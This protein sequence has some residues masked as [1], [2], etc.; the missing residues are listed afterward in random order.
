M[1][2]LHAQGIRLVFDARTGL[3][4]SFAVTDGGREVAPLHRAPWVGTDEAMPPDAAPLMAR[5]GGDFFCAPFGGSE[6]DSP[7]HGWP[8]NTPW[9]IAAQ[10]GRV[11]QARLDRT[12]F[13]AELTKH[14]SLRDGHPFVYQSHAF[15]GGTCRVSVANHANVSLRS[16]GILRTSRKRHWETPKNAQESDPTRGRSALLYPALAADPARFPGL[17]GPV[18][19]TRYPWAPRHEDFVIG[20]EAPG[21]ALGWT[22][23]TR[24]AEHD[25]FLS[26]RDPRKLPMTMLWHSNGGRDYAPWWGRHFGCLGVEEGAAG[27]ML[28]LSTEDLL[29]G[30]GAVDLAAGRTTTIR[31]VIGAVDWPSGEAVHDITRSG[32]SLHVVGEGGASR[33][34]PF[35]GAFLDLNDAPPA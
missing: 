8:P 3:L 24:P 29:T 11:L 22:A 7:L 2:D 32:N 28:G 18:D 20:I 19:L 33:H 13:G 23:V 15:T 6:G 17:V 16:G 14:L 4:D 34:I 27:H 26:L 9:T 5:L 25:L 21:H 1:T 12:V 35:D 10:D 31:H 30:P